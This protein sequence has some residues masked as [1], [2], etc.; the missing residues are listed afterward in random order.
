MIYI[1]L[2]I[3]NLT[4]NNKSNI[5]IPITFKE[6]LRYFIKIHVWSKASAKYRQIEVL[7]RIKELIRNGNE[8]ESIHIKFFNEKVI[9]WI[10]SL[11][12]SDQE[13]TGQGSLYLEFPDSQ[14]DTLGID[15]EFIQ[16]NHS[17]VHNL[18]IED[19]KRIQILKAV[20]SYARDKY[21]ESINYICLFS[22]DIA[23]IFASK[24]GKK[25]KNFRGAVNI[26]CNP[27]MSRKKKINYNFLGALLWPIYYVRN[28][29]A[30][31]HPKIAFDKSLTEML[32]ENLTQIVKYLANKKIFISS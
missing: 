8:I 27:E 28:Q 22:E 32:L 2:R 5:S 20:E 3:K 9:E 14:R 21:R 31:S 12:Y 11:S 25:F 7:L 30:H 29:Q 19:N 10:P 17:I 26:L 24:T 6:Y 1:S 4:L 13:F 18:K 16:Y 23:R 15:I